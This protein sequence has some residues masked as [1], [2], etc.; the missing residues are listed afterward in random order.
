MAF[1]CFGAELVSPR[2]F[3]TSLELPT[4]RNCP[5]RPLFDRMLPDGYDRCAGWSSLV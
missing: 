4:V 5:F 2:Q 1:T 3:C